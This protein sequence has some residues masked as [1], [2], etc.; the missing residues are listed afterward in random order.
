MDIESEIENL[1]AS[2]N[3]R[4]IPSETREGMIDL[5]SNDYLGLGADT[6]FR[7]RMYEAAAEQMLPV[8]SSASRLLAADQRQYELLENMLS[9]MYQGKKALLF[10]SGYHANAGIVAALAGK[11]AVIM[12]D[13]LAHASIYD[14][15]L[16]T[17][18]TMSRWP[19]NNYDRLEQLVKSGHSAGKEVLIIAESVYSMDGDRADIQRLVE[20]KRKYPGTLLYVDEAH[21]FGV[22][23]P[24]GLGLTVA[25]GVL[26]EV[27]VVVGTFG[28]AVASVGAFAIVSE[29]MRHFLVNHARSL[30]FSTALPPVNALWTRMLIERM[31]GM[32]AERK[33]LR[34]IGAR[35]GQIL[36]TGSDSHIQPLIIGDAKRAVALSHKL[37][38]RGIK[39]LPIRK[40]TVP[41]GTERL[42]F[43]LSAALS[44]GQIE[45]VGNVLNSLSYPQC[46]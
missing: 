27:D 46:R 37:S 18:A 30:I 21:A 34:A 16:M 41:P 15:A 22:E 20:I 32:D 44:M 24:S 5:T 31:T 45:H 23:G 19:H 29:A 25:A 42:R 2:G 14:G 40:P 26:D 4:E 6:T 33:H 1:R 9:D 36:G 13:R 28:K 11:N 38:E 8:T 43:S 12:P 35:M 17:L 7:K 3:F 10:N 39:A